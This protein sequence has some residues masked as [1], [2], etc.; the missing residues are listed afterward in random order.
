MNLPKTEFKNNWIEILITSEHLYKLS[1][2]WS[3]PKSPLNRSKLSEESWKQIYALFRSLGPQVVFE[4]E[5]DL[6][7]TYEN[8][9]L[10][11]LT[12]EDIR[13]TK[14]L[15]DFYLPKQLENKNTYNKFIDPRSPLCADIY[16]SIITTGKI[17]SELVPLLST[18]G[19]S[20][21]KGTLEQRVQKKLNESIQSAIF[22][23]ATQEL[24]IKAIPLDPFGNRL[25]RGSPGNISDYD[26]IIDG[27]KIRIDLKLVKDL[28]ELS[29]Q[30]PH[31]SNLLVGANWKTGDTDYYI[32]NDPLNIS[33]NRKFIALI[34]LFSKI[35]KEASKIYIHI[36]KIDLNG[37]VDYI[38]FGNNY[39]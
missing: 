31:D 14:Y 10:I 24:G 25:Y 5:A 20:T 29:S 17:N 34:A 15:L 8:S 36:N 37:S 6:C 7:T 1:E 13:G 32:I 16:N 28:T 4:K 2:N 12:F 35:L 9:L 3:C 39:K 19:S 30:E 18:I 23:Y 27:L 11:W 38:L 26:L 33:N 21:W 22:E